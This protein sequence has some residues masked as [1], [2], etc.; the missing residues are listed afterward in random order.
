MTTVFRAETLPLLHFIQYR[1]CEHRCTILD[2][3]VPNPDNPAQSN[4]RASLNCLLFN[5]ELAQVDMTVANLGTPEESVIGSAPVFN[6]ERKC[7]G[8]DRV[9]FLR[10]AGSLDDHFILRHV[11][12]MGTRLANKLPPLVEEEGEWSISCGGDGI[13]TG[14]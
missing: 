2:S 8:C 13:E 4:L 7:G 12:A 1:W 11:I 10:E 9:R 6:Q 3:P 14:T 5:V